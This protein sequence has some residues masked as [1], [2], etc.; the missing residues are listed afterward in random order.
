MSELLA[1]VHVVATRRRDG[2]PA[3][4]LFVAQALVEL[5]R[6]RVSS[7]VAAA[8]NRSSSSVRRWSSA[9]SAVPMVV[10][11][12]PT[13]RAYRRPRTCLWPRLVGGG[14]WGGVIVRSWVRVG[15]S[16]RWCRCGRGGSGGRAGWSTRRSRARHAVAPGGV[17]LEAVVEAAQRG[18]VRGR[19]R[20]GL[21]S[22]F[23]FGVVVVVDDV[24]DVAAARGRVHHGNT[25]VRSRRMSVRGSGRGSRTPAS[26]ARR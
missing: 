18:E 8:L 12:S 3:E 20:A 7:G 4:D 26:T 24:V 10:R 1:Q 11:T 6:L 25:Q 17:G 2:L 16:T 14:V 23:C 13:A 15:R 9:A 21:W 5:R 22:A 19:G